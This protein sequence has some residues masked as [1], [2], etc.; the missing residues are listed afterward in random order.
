MNNRAAIYVRVST[1]MQE[2][3][4]DSLDAQMDLA[5]RF[6]EQRGLVIVKTYTDTLSGQSGE[7]PGLLQLEADVAR[8]GAFDHL[9]VYRLD[10]LWRNSAAYHALLSRLET[11][12][13]GLSSLTEPSRPRRWRSGHNA[14]ASSCG[15]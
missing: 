15:R 12:G 14:T 6:C 1:S 8:G 5:R 10:R 7:R 9:L 4:G 11:A 2:R 3:D 13:V